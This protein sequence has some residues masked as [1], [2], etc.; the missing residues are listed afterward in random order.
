M[1][2]QQIKNEQI[3]NAFLLG[4]AAINANPMRLPWQDAS[5]ME[6]LMS[7]R[8]DIPGSASFNELLDAWLRGWDLQDLD[9]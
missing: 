6:L 9:S 5:L 1:N 7:H 2:T 3:K 4:R 8:S